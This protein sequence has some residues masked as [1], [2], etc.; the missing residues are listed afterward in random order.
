M[1][2]NRRLETAETRVKEL[3][4]QMM[5]LNLVDSASSSSSPTVEMT[6]NDNNDNNKDRV[7][8]EFEMI[9]RRL[10][11][12]L[13]ES[14]NLLSSS[15]M[16]LEEMETRLQDSE[17]QRQILQEKLD[18]AIMTVTTETVTPTEPASDELRE[19][20]QENSTATA[21]MNVI[22]GGKDGGKDNSSGYDRSSV[23][24]E[25]LLL[26]ETRLK[27]LESVIQHTESQLAHSTSSLEASEARLFSKQ[28]RL[29]E[30]EILLKSLETTTTGTSAISSGSTDEVSDGSP[31]TG[32]GDKLQDTIKRLKTAEKKVKEL[33]RSLVQVKMSSLLETEKVLEES[34]EIQERLSMVEMEL[35][36]SNSTIVE[37]NRV[38]GDLRR[39]LT[40]IEQ[41]IQ[42]IIT[43]LRQELSDV[44]SQLVIMTDTSS[45]LEIRLRMSESKSKELDAIISETTAALIEKSG[46]LKVTE[47]KL[48]DR[49][50][51]I[52]DLETCLN[53]MQEELSV[54]S[55][56]L[57]ETSMKLLETSELL[58]ATSKELE[59]CLEKIDVLEKECDQHAGLTEENRQ[60]KNAVEETRVHADDLEARMDAIE[61][62]AV[63]SVDRVEVVT[64]ALTLE[65]KDAQ[66][67]LFQKGLKLMQTE[68]RVVQLEQELDNSNIKMEELSI[69]LETLS[70]ELE[71][72]KQ[73]LDDCK[74][75]LDKSEKKLEKNIEESKNVRCAMED[76]FHTEKQKLLSQIELFEVKCASS[77]R[78]T[79]T[80]EFELA[81]KTDELTALMA[82][83]THSEA[84]ILQLEM[85]LKATEEELADTIQRMRDM[86][87]SKN[88]GS[89]QLAR[90]KTQL[91]EKETKLQE[92][93][94]RLKSSRDRMKELE[95]RVIESE[96]GFEATTDELEQCRDELKQ[97]QHKMSEYEVQLRELLQALKSKEEQLEESNKRLSA[98]GAGD[99]KQLHHLTDK[100]AKL[101]HT[102]DLLSTRLVESEKTN[103]ALLSQLRESE[104]EL[105]TARS[106]ERQGSN[107]SINSN[108]TDNEL[109]VKLN[110]SEVKIAAQEKEIQSLKT[111][112]EILRKTS[113]TVGG[114]PEEEIFDLRNQLDAS[115]KELEQLRIVRGPHDKD[116]IRIPGMI[117]VDE[118]EYGLILQNY[119]IILNEL[120]EV[121]AELEQ[122]R[123]W[124]LE[125]E[126]VAV[127]MAT[128]GFKGGRR[129]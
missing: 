25:K 9:V 87:E 27:E 16:A 106:T 110:D 105:K 122:E 61:A 41:E 73:D 10:K 84:Q 119:N 1:A 65:L 68:E 114:N 99:S 86:D 123:V 29:A 45:S 90:I 33:E 46:N 53:N 89:N 88:V 94:A 35:G 37:L 8:R 52:E 96:H 6:V 82:S 66:D 92:T 80:L 22:A 109:S 44:N 111:K 57:E 83:V 36:T 4:Q 74:W 63:T 102:I 97:F 26:S 3:E 115:N 71:D 59:D 70:N 32:G 107:E 28:A 69:V 38:N 24:E 48:V 20:E 14:E 47:A 23:L 56:N 121:K 12:D 51:H 2:M 129:T 58:T 50:A 64:S 91:T 7:S 5:M 39:E 100:S 95:L 124:R 40:R 67:T 55:A 31:G 60:L 126:D 118:R 113:W 127:S 93:E 79:T 104:A 98:T 117:Y 76:N 78:I 13:L 42:P 75:K 43:A 18:A 72:Y 17:T 30:V 54:T 15:N 77:D 81:A 21:D 85:T 112:L 49:D 125:A 108:G 19:T 11:L 120:D 116:G 34:E 62:R 103:S 128:K 101:Q